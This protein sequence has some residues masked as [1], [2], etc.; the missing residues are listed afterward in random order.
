MLFTFEN[1]N[2]S[3]PFSIN[4]GMNDRNYNYAKIQE[5]IKDE[6]RDTAKTSDTSNR[7]GKYYV[8]AGCFLIPKNAENQ[9]LKLQKL[10]FNK[11]YKFNFPESEFYSVVVDTFHLPTEY[12]E[13][14]GRLQ[15]NNVEYFIKNR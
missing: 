1:E 14:T 6:V 10:G 13:L 5:L 2:H 8:I 4:C 3:N 9:V 11:S 15:K 12:I 7:S